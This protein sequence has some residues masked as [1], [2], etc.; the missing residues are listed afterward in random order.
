MTTEEQKARMDHDTVNTR[1]QTLVA[2]R[3]AL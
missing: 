2:S 3:K 1:L